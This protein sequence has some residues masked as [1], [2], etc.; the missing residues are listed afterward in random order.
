MEILG[1]IKIKIITKLSNSDV[2]SV[3]IKWDECKTLSD[4]EGQINSSFKLNSSDDSLLVDNI[5]S[6]TFIKISTSE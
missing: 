1:I 4:Y 2:R 5:V 3:E 6:G